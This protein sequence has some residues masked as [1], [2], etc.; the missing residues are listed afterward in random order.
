M[1]KKML[2][3]VRLSEVL[4]KLIDHYAIERGGSRADAVEW[5]LNVGLNAENFQWP[6]THQQE[7]DA[8]LAAAAETS[9]E[10]T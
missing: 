7:A 5:L 4:V 9:E 1:S 2:V 8:A 6:P 3:Q 10:E